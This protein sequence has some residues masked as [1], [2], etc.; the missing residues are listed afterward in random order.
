MQ[1]SL[2]PVFKLETAPPKD[3]RERDARDKVEH[4]A[5][6]FVNNLLVQ[7]KELEAKL[8][9]EVI[10]YSL[11]CQSVIPHISAVTKRLPIQWG[12]EIPPFEIRKH[13]KS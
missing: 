1:I 13:Y 12:F 5:V 4:D 9:S 8:E 7:T 3:D 6:I 2:K 10:F 11:E